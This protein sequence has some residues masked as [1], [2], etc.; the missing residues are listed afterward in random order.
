VITWT[1][2]PLVRSGESSTRATEFAKF[3][4]T[5]AVR[6]S[7]CRPSSVPATRAGPVSGICVLTPVAGSISARMPRAV[8]LTSSQPRWV[9]SMPLRPK[10]PVAAA[11]PVTTIG[12][13]A[14]NVPFAPIGTL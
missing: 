5:Q 2:R 14:P 4:T 12:C 7:S 9:E 6:P 8:W 11:G 3:C 13:V 10:P 1:T